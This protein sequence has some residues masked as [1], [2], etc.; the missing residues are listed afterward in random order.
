MLP[1]LNESATADGPAT[2]DGAATSVAPAAADA[3][4][5]ADAET[6]TAPAAPSLEALE[7]DIAPQGFLEPCLA[8]NHM[9]QTRAYHNCVDV[10]KSIQ[11]NWHED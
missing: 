2:A 4:A 10:K 8:G 7:P 9:L 3:P 1:T 11:Y 6:C 5:T